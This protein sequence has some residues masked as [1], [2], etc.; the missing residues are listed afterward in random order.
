MRRLRTISPA[1]TRHGKKTKPKRKNARAAVGQRISSVADLQEQVTFL[2]RK[3]A[4]AREQQT[5]T[6]EV[7][8]VISSS[9]GELDPVFKGMLENATR[10]CGAKLGVLY[11]REGDAFRVAAHHN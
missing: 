7:L 1:K 6:S 9:P 4:E 3:L 10:I 8:R 5:A 2:A 11:L